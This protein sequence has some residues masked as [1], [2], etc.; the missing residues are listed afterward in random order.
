MENFEYFN[1]TR[2]VFGKGQINKLGA[3]IKSFGG[4][5]VLVHYGGNSAKLS[6]V[7]YGVLNAL[8]EAGIPYV[9]F[10]GVVP[11]PRLG[12]AL[13]GAELA[14]KEKV[15]FILA[16]GGGSVIDSAKCLASA[17][18]D[19]NV[20]DCFMDN[21]KLVSHALPVG[22]VL[23]I[24]AAGSESSNGAVITNEKTGLKR[25]ACSDV[26]LPKF[27]IVDPE[28]TYTLPDNQI[29][30][31]ITDIL[32][33][34]MERYFTAVPVVDLTNH[35]LEGAM[36][37]H[38]QNGLKVLSDNRNYD[39]RSELSL[40]AILAHNNMFGVGRIGDWASH[41]IEHEL[42]AINDIAHGAGLAIVFPAWMKY[43]HQN[44]VGNEIFARFAKY[45]FDVE[46]SED[47]NAVIEEGIKR[48]EDFYHK[49]GLKT[50][51]SEAGI[52][53][54]HF[55]KISE[56]AVLGRGTIGNLMKLSAEDVYQILILAK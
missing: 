41:C 49:L 3:L 53:E 4:K 1:P 36:K 46:E 50:T 28:F 42:S 34:M 27:A 54:K 39:L 22:V 12:H 20:W 43:L 26:M 9:E 40:A 29:A 33:H 45:V 55:E 31:G 14:I 11:N 18:F 19:E 21:S 8:D 44:G 10:G 52:S 47:Q 56:N 7:L 35:I 30:Y 13:K 2:I 25:D 32:A 6:G 15:N 38:I 16:V 24:P 5:K 37:S 51:L 23:T 17:V 48:L